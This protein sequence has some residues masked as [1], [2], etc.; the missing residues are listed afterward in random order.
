M[1]LKKNQ[2]VVFEDGHKEGYLEARWSNKKNA[3]Y[4]FT[5]EGEKIYSTTIIEKTPRTRKTKFA[6]TSENCNIQIFPSG[7]TE[8]AYQVYA[9]SNGLIGRGKRDYYEYIAKSICFV[10][11]DGN[12]Y[13]PAWAIRD[14]GIK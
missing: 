12:I 11:A 10:D 1:E 4:T 2:F 5:D 6:P 7:Q 9:G 13:A 3:F 8:K 14:K